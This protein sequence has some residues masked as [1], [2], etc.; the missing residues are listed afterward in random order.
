MLLEIFSKKTECELFV[1][2]S[3]SQERDF[4]KEYYKELY[5]TK[6]IHTFGFVNVFSEQ[7]K[8][9]SDKCAYL[10]FPSCAEGQA[11]SIT[12]AMS[13]GCI[14]IISKMC[15]FSEREGIIL[16]DCSMKCIEQYIDK[17]S[18]MDK[19]WIVK[20]CKKE[21]E[22]I[23]ND[24]S[25]ESFVESVNNALDGVLYATENNR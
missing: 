21:V 12:T 8:E 11:G 23:A 15:G 6:N 20:Q 1:C 18:Q 17:Y 13:A 7:F 14:P 19:E 4:E 22:I 9:I 5:K 24:Y 16:G 25:E 2:S 3:I 10:I